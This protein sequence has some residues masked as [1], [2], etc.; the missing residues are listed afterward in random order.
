[1][2]LDVNNEKI[3]ERYNKIILSL[4]SLVR[5][6]TIGKSESSISVT[7]SVHGTMISGDLVSVENFHKYMKTTLLDNLDQ[8]NDAEVYEPI[9]DALQILE[10]IKIVDEDNNFIFNYICIKNPRI[11]LSSSNPN[12]APYWIGKLDSIDGFFL[13]TMES[14]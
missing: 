6:V 14:E 10:N 9:R 5:I 7:I 12:F 3:L 2:P 4:E 1:M 11:F 13:G 8:N